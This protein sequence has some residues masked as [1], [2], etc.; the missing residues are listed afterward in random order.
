MNPNL[1]VGDARSSVSK[2]HF[3]ASSVN[4]G[5]S[6]LYV[7]GPTNSISPGSGGSDRSRK[8]RASPGKDGE[9]IAEGQQN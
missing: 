5:Q 7:A 4:D 9:N 8:S 2:V 1:L 3:D 6:L